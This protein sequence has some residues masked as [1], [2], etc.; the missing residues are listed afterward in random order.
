M[1]FLQVGQTGFKLL[2]SNDPP[3]SDSQSAGITGVSHGTQPEKF[4]SHKT[5]HKLYLVSL[6]YHSGWS[7]VVQSWLTATSTSLVQM[8]LMP[9]PPDV[10]H[11]VFL[12]E[13]G[14]RHVGQAGLKLWASSDLPT[15]SSQSAEITG[16]LDLSPR[17]ECSGSLQPLPPG[18]KQF[19]CFSRLS[20]WDYRDKILL[21]SRVECNRAI[22]A[23]CSLKLR[24]SSN[25]STSTSQ[26]GL[27][28]L[29]Q[30]ILL[31][32]P[33]KVLGIQA[34]LLCLLGWRAVV[35]SQLTELLPPGFK[36]FSCLSLSIETGFHHAG[37]A[38][39]ELLTSGDPPALASQSA[40]ITEMVFP[41][42]AQAGLELLSSSAP[43]ASAPRSAR[44][45][46]LDLKLF[47]RRYC[48]FM[49]PLQ[50]VAQNW[51]S[52]R[53]FIVIE[54]EQMESCSVAQA[55]VQ[56]CDLGSLQPPPPGFKQL[57]C[58]SLSR[59]WDYRHEPPCPANFC[60]FSKDGISPCWPGWSSTPNLMILPPW[61]LKVLGLQAQSLALVA[62]AGAQ[63]RDVGSPQ[64]PPPGFKRFSYLSLLSSWEYRLEGRPRLISWVY[65]GKNKV[66]DLTTAFASQLGVL[67]S[68]PFRVSAFFFIKMGTTIKNRKPKKAQTMDTRWLCRLPAGC[69]CALHRGSVGYRG[70]AP[71]LCPVLLPTAIGLSGGCG[72]YVLT[73]P[74]PL[75]ITE[76]P[77]T[78]LLSSHGGGTLWELSWVVSDC[79]FLYLGLALLPSLGCSGTTAAHYSLELLG[80]SDP[81]SSASCRIMTTGMCHHVQLISRGLWGA[82]YSPELL[83][84][85]DP[86]TSVS[87]VTGTTGTCHRARQAAYFSKSQETSERKVIPVAERTKS[88]AC[89]Y[90]RKEVHVERDDSGEGFDKSLALSPRLESSGAILA[91]CNLCLPGS[92]DSPASASR[93]AGITGLHHHAWLP[94][95]ELSCVCSTEDTSETSDSELCGECLM[96]EIQLLATIEGSCSSTNEL[97][98]DLESLALLPRLECS[99]TILAHCSL[100]L[101]DSKM[102][103]CHVGQAGLELLTSVC[104]LPFS[105]VLP[106]KVKWRLA[107][108]PRLECSDTISA[109]CSLCLQGSSD[110][111]AS[112]S[113][114]A[115]ITETGFHYVGQAGLEHL[116][117]QS[118]RLGLPKCWDYRTE[119]RLAQKYNEDSWNKGVCRF[120]NLTVKQARSQGP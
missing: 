72:C 114:V 4:F 21:S 86:P 96:T 52:I 80:L 111:P 106:A 43:P 9:Q 51:V 56:W 90:N 71:Q 102:G 23:H 78:P 105:K 82:H 67:T 3:T 113:R 30:T 99:S 87:R 57:S 55:G 2:T 84:S 27:K 98:L 88:M 32:C 11:H 8:I 17:L 35:Q 63:W 74:M 20:S 73:Q 92:S 18:F 119:T 104:T 19:S 50:R 91:H 76:V 48:L 60:I 110:S 53:R 36:R 13:T 5:L 100:C 81:P 39:F 107:L 70:T 38:G 28:L 66:P 34:V 83:G 29:T 14:F 1:G 10:H 61:L 12:A 68:Q 69:V 58:L 103:F 37:Q 108:L 77:H 120:Q 109:H 46:E 41:H 15:S 40:G 93:V 44:I 89:V 49:F 24:G 42:I 79:S 117:S 26:T 65:R 118:T 33:F 25:L 116:T 7:T 115:G 16:G 54:N 45:R 59:S 62:Q 75:R 31:L 94:C 47:K 85:S 95:T 97:T 112:A 22:I 6:C 101:Q 64:P